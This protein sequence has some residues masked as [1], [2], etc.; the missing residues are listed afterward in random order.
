METTGL[1]AELWQRWR[2]FASE[3]LGVTLDEEALRRFETFARALIEWNAKM[4]L[5]SVRSAEEILWR[6]FADSLA[7]VRLIEKC[8][9]SASLSIADIGSGAGLPGLPV[10]IARPA[11]RLTLIESITK[12]C[13][14]IEHARETLG[15]EG[16][17]IINNRVENVAQDKGF[18]GRFDA[19]LSRAVTKLSPNLELALPLLR[20]G[21]H[22]LIFKT[23]ATADEH[24]AAKNALEIL[25]GKL[26][27]TFYYDLPGSKES[28]AIL[29]FEKTGDTPPAYPRRAGVPE[30]KP[31]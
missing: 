19:V 28:Y 10:K 8:V 2:D 27:D 29:C 11:W 3:K 26:A 14:F 25:K 16:I 22:A 13:S 5:V 30:K 4:N 23:R 17:E 20:S 7:C 12:K 1:T 15:L 24:P 18:R 21:G 6:H 9:P 31:L